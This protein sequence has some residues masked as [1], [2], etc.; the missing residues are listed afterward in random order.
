MVQCKKC[1]NF[2]IPVKGLINYCSLSCRN[3][4]G[5]RSFKDRESISKGV[6]NSEKSRQANLLQ[7][8]RTSKFKKPRI[9]TICLFCNR[10]IIHSISVTRKY[11]LECWRKC[12]GG[13][14]EN[15]T[16]KHCSDYSGSRM[17]SGAE[18]GFVKF[19][20]NNQI[21]WTKNSTISFPY[22][23]SDF[24]V[25]NYYPDFYLPTF[26]YWVEIKGKF[27]AELD[28]NVEIKK[29]LIENYLF[30]DSND[31]KKLTYSGI[32]G[33]MGNLPDC[34]LGDLDSNS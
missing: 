3:S 28:S 6:L 22:T 32:L 10:P 12:S 21:K 14:R 29:T 11:H 24:K 19:C 34:L 2:F 16:I 1:E 33:L 27:Y 26:D 23:G 9:E 25:H 31:V 30:I 8:G 4:R 18:L 13:F 17:D 20:E 15:S 5:V 7:K